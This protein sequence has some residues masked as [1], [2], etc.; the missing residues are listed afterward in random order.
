MIWFLLFIFGIGLIAGITLLV[1]GIVM[2]CAGKKKGVVIQDNGDEYYTKKGNKKTAG[3]LFTVFGGVLTL[4]S[5]I[6]VIFSV[7]AAMAV[8]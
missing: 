4:I 3:V 1:I 8:L 7:I 5:I 6:I 2:L